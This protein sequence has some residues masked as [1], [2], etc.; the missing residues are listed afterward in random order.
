MEITG[1]LTTDAVVNE[2]K[3]NGKVVNFTIAINDTYKKYGADEVK[4]VTTFVNCSYWL[5]AGIA[6]ALT[7][8][9]LVELFGR[10]GVKAWKTT[11]GEPRATLT[12]HVNSIKLLGKAKMANGSAEDV[13]TRQKEETPF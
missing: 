6:T 12:F 13:T 8:G 5:N 11:E 4:K 9:M 2:T 3:E 1:R 7:K 10:I